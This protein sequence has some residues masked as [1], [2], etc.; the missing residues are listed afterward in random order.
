MADTED[1]RR[2]SEIRARC[3]EATSGPWVMWPIR[4]AFPDRYQVYSPAGGN[5]NVVQSG[6]GVSNGAFVASARDDVPWLLDLVQSQLRELAEL[7]GL[8][9]DLCEDSR[10]AATAVR[11][12]RALEGVAET[13]RPWVG[14]YMSRPVGVVYKVAC[15]ALKGNANGTS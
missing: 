11:Y 4:S 9:A 5:L 8:L 6:V 7:R 2:L 15:E 14:S 1:A 10:A 13:L 3:D 12:R